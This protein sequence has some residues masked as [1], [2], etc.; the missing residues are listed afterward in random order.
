M[1]GHRNHDCFIWEA[2]RATSAAPLFFEPVTL[3][4]SN[5]TFF[6]GALR[7]NNPIYEVSSEARRLWPHRGIGCLVSLGAGIKTTKAFNMQ[8]SRLHEVLQSLADIA[9]DATATAR[10]YKDTLQGRDLLQ[11]NKYFRFSVSQG[12]DDVDLADSEKIQYM[13][14]MTVPYVRDNDV[15]MENCARNLAYPSSIC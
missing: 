7:A 13:E 9:T 1:I 6:D 10:K 2:A 3:E 11:G 5:T 15:S 12:M 14:S 4:T 8:K